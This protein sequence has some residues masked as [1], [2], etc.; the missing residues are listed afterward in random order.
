MKR[1][2]AKCKGSH[3]SDHQLRALFDQTLQ[4]VVFL[5]PD[6]T[7]L[8]ANLAALEF[9]HVRPKNVLGRKLWNTPWW[10][11]SFQAQRDLKQALS[12][13]A[14]GKI[15][16]YELELLNSEGELATFDFA[17]SPVK[18]SGGKVQMILAEGREISERKRIER[19]LVQTRDELELRVH[20]RT[21]Q[22]A[23]TSAQLKAGLEGRRRIEQALQSNE[24]RLRA[25]L[26]TAVDGIITIDAKGIIESVNPAAEQ[27]FGYAAREILGRN[28]RM[29]MPEPYR[30]EHD[31]YLANYLRTGRAKIIGIGREVTGLR[32]DGS[33]FPMELAVSEVRLGS[34]RF[35]TGL[36]RDVT[37]RRRL[38]REILEIS[39]AEQLRIGQDLHD[40]LCQQLTG[41]AFAL[42]SLSR[43]GA[44]HS[45]KFAKLNG[46]IEQ[47]AD[48][49]DQAITQA[50]GLARGLCPVR[51]EAEGLAEALRELAA[52][53]SEIYRVRCRFEGDDHVLLHD[54]TAAIHLYRI[55]Q[56]A[57]S[58]AIRHGKAKRIDLS[59]SQSGGNIVLTVR[60][61]GAGLPD[62]S[63]RGRGMGLYI[64][65]YRAKMIGGTCVV[66]AAPRRGTLVT[67][68]MPA[69]SQ[70]IRA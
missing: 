53:T 19:A 5:S 9:R 68:S 40:G 31:A 41:I 48:L 8:E 6:G 7:V 54:N 3:D 22:L 69:V 35:F 61:D 37:E 59:L 21:A 13:C 12:R 66:R 67:C 2:P 10:D 70:A 62:R 15:V 4:F 14:G 57:V 52:N 38:E 18:D 51:L 30:S 63:R 34:Q 44:S 24:Q 60:D 26:E 23:D 1:P 25:I 16:R 55:A 27:L 65:Q 32:K 29:L 64:M 36:V 46:S 39:H 28:V 33:T 43:A 17:V 45:T 56:E 50:R 42:A 49:V 47:I 11:I 20:E 58:N